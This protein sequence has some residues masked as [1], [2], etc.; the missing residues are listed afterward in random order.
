MTTYLITGRYKGG[1]WEELD[2][3]EG[4]VESSRVAMEYRLA[5]GIGWEIRRRIK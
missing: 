4:N 5:F 1:D 3:I 2:E